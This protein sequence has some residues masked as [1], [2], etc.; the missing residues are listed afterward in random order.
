MSGRATFT[1]VTSISSMNV[2]RQTVISGSHL[3][4][5]IPTFLAVEAGGS[6][7]GGDELGLVEQA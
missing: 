6:A 3:R 5:S 4:M 7:G 2:P 1:I